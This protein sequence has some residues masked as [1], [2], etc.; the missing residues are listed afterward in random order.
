MQATTDT[1]T[2]P[3]AQAPR[4]S[5]SERVQRY[6]QRLKAKGGARIPSGYL[7]PEQAQQVAELLAS[8][9]ASTQSGVVVAAIRDAHKKMQRNKK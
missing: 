7:T 4:L 6:T 9:Y 3:D 5:G 1:N 8:G 2:T